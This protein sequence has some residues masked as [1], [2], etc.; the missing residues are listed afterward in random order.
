METFKVQGQ[1]F[2]GYRGHETYG[3]FQRGN[4]LVIIDGWRAVDVTKY[5][6][7]K[8]ISINEFSYSGQMYK[9]EMELKFG[10][11]KAIVNAQLIKSAV[12]GH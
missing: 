10:H 11:E 9:D 8:Q 3:Q 7:R 12:S 4:S 6:P 5:S 2:G 1:P